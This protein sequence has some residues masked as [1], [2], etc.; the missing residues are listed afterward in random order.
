[1]ITATEK[2]WGF[3][4]TFTTSGHYDIKCPVGT[5]IRASEKF[6]TIFAGIDNLHARSVV[7]NGE[8]GQWVYGHLSVIQKTGTIQE[9]EYFALSG[10]W[11]PLPG[12]QTTGPH[13]HQSLQKNGKY[14]DFIKLIGESM[15]IIVD[16]NA[17]SE[18]AAAGYIKAA[19]NMRQQL[20]QAMA[21]WGTSPQDIASMPDAQ[22]AQWAKDRIA[23]FKNTQSMSLRDAWNIIGQKIGI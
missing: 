15:P 9:G 3:S 4:N 19:M 20:D 1:M 14:I 18:Q 16:G 11:P 22:K 7:G 12:E 13:L 23:E 17:Y 21:I 6:N 10:G 8:H 2:D 5:P